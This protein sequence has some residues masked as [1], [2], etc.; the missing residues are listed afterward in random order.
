MS[1]KS[2]LAADVARQQWRLKKRHYGS[3]SM[4]R[5][6]PRSHNL[7]WHGVWRGSGGGGSEA[8]LGLDVHGPVELG[9]QAPVEDLLHGHLPHQQHISKLPLCV[10]CTLKQ[11]DLLVSRDIST[12]H[13][14][15]QNTTQFLRDLENLDLEHWKFSTWQSERC[16][17]FCCSCSLYP[18]KDV[19]LASQPTAGRGHP[20]NCCS[21]S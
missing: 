1:T 15:C 14:G 3:V 13:T 6:F 7:C 16:C 8:P 9:Q 20:V 2:L 21:F 17:P 19:S 10:C 12:A 4:A 5:Y 11:C 18:C